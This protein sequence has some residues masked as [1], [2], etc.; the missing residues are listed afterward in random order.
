[1]EIQKS[2]RALKKQEK[3][4]PFSKILVQLQAFKE[5]HLENQS[6]SPKILE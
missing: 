1:M 5:K 4:L 2:Y 6:Y 3:L